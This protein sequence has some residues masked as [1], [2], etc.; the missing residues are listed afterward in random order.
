MELVVLLVVSVLSAGV[1]AALDPSGRWDGK[2]MIPEREMSLTVDLARTPAG[3]WVGSLS[4]PLSSSID[5]PLGTI[6][7]DGTV[8]TF[9]ALLPGKATF[10]GKLSTDGRRLTG[11]ASNAEGSAPFQLART[12]DASVKL[13]PASSP[14]PKEFEGA[15]EGTVDVSGTVKKIGLKLSTASDGTAVG[16]LIG[17]EPGA[18]EI[19]V[20]VVTVKG[21]QLYLESRA[22]SGTFNGTL[23]DTGEIAGEWTQ[24]TTRLPLTFRKVTAR[25]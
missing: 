21:A 20:T 14:L 10:E 9:S 22:V 13:P 4:I 3:S 19:P 16:V 24:R 7:I 12:G 15:W 23:G 2:I 6:T 1:Q 5:V 25:K 11:T 8:V 18:P 17:S